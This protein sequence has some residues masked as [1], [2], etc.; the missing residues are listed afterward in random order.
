M[1]PH[2]GRLT[3]VLAGLLM[4][5][6]PNIAEAQLQQALG[7]VPSLSRPLIF[8][9]IPKAGGST[10][11]DILNDYCHAHH[12]RCVIPCYNSL[13]CT[14]NEA[15]L[16]LPHNLNNTACAVVLGGHWNGGAL[17]LLAVLVQVDLGTYGPVACKRWPWLTEVW[18]ELETLPRAPYIVSFR[19]NRTKRLECLAEVDGLVYDD[20][21]QAEYLNAQP[22]VK[23]HHLCDGFPPRRGAHGLALQPLQ[24]CITRFDAGLCST[25]WHS[26]YHRRV[27]WRG[28]AAHVIGRDNEARFRQAGY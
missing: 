14:T 26:C 28:P 2:N 19:L 22:A 9:H 20:V 10:L 15:G 17:G 12:L 13:V 1:P 7:A 6:M 11:R 4:L 8:Q 21:P 3:S 27:W 24:L 25:A 5:I 18:P 16:I 23:S